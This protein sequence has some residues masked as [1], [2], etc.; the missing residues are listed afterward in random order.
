M[1]LLSPQEKFGH[2]AP[3]KPGLGSSTR[4]GPHCVPSF[5]HIEKPRIW[6]NN[7]N[8]IFPHVWSMCGCLLWSRV[9]SA[10]PISKQDVWVRDEGTRQCRPTDS[11]QPL[12]YEV[13]GGLSMAGQERVQLRGQIPA[14]KRLRRAQSPNIQARRVPGTSTCESGSPVSDSRNSIAEKIPTEVCFFSKYLTGET[15][16][17]S[18]LKV[19]LSSPRR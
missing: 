17:P 14:H 18:T 10:A 11:A 4:H 7:S 16:H 1:L 12:G 9:S 5:P 13:R 19:V 3:W 15:R 2:T 8:F 6:R